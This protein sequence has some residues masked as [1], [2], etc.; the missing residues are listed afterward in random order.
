MPIY[1][2]KCTKCDIKTNIVKSVN[3][4]DKE[5]LCKTCNTKLSRVYSSIGIS[6]SGSGFYSTDK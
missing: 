2:Y 5:E 1:E 3:D 4:L 6:F